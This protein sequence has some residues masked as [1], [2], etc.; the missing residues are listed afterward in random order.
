MS[1]ETKQLYLAA[2]HHGL[3]DTGF[4]EGR[5]VAVEKAR[6]VDKPLQP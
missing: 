1:H 5:N 3:G 4:V 6:Q 2:F